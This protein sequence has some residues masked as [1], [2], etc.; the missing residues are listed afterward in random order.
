MEILT[1]MRRTALCVLL[2]FPFFDGCDEAVPPELD[3]NVDALSPVFKGEPPTDLTVTVLSDSVIRL[4]WKNNS[5]YTK[6]FIIERSLNNENAFV[7]VGRVGPT[8]TSFIDS[9]A[10]A[11]FCYMYRVRMSNIR[12]AGSSEVQ[13]TPYAVMNRLGDNVDYFR[14]SPSGQYVAFSRNDTITVVD[15]SDGGV[16]LQH[17]GAGNFALSDE[18]LADVSLFTTTQI[19]R[20][21]NIWRI[22]DGSRFARFDVD[23]QVDGMAFTHSGNILACG[24]GFGLNLW[25][26]D[27]SPSPT[28]Q[29]YQD[30]SLGGLAELQFS[31]DDAHLIAMVPTIPTCTFTVYSTKP[32]QPV[33][34]VT[35][36]NLVMPHF[37]NNTIVSYW[38]DS[39]VFYD[40]NQGRFVGAIADTF[41]TGNVYYPEYGV[42]INSTGSIVSVYYTT[43]VSFSE[44][45]VRF[46][47]LR[48]CTLLGRMKTIELGNE[49]PAESAFSRRNDFLLLT[50]SKNLYLWRYY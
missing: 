12:T 47:L 45:Q 32:W 40:L 25:N 1:Y 4:K 19:Q 46:W 14:V 13:L 3:N 50:N 24:S 38:N 43:D 16:L 31:E 49:I 34:R 6:G 23:G 33:Y 35:K 10:R 17:A 9:S 2:S 18:Y 30:P 28:H 15:L 20:A 21:V 26:L 39:L 36:P 37:V 8:V 41:N 5:G 42:N 7:E 11:N 29:V 48:N 22:T 27:A 44:K